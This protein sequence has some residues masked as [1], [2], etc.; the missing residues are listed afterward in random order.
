MEH[1]HG[2]YAYEPAIADASGI[3]YVPPAAYNPYKKWF[4]V[5]LQLL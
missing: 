1:Q 4:I 2:R 5:V 3:L